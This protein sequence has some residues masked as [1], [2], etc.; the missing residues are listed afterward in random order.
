MSDRLEMERRL[1][2]LKQRKAELVKRINANDAQLMGLSERVRGRTLPRREYEDIVSKQ[3]AFKK[4]LM[5]DRAACGELSTEIH[6]LSVEKEAIKSALPPRADDATVVGAVREAITALRDKYTRF[7]KDNTRVSS[8][9]I[10]ASELSSDLNE[11]LARMR[12]L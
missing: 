7:S 10:M 12:D 3:A 9:R 2:A 6:S 8:M 5:R 11:L 1:A 4:A